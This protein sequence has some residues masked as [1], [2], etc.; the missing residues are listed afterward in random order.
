MTAT[1]IDGKAF[2]AQVRGQVAQHVTRLKDDHG[3]TPGL[4]VVLV[5][6]DPASEVYVK[7]K[8]KMTKEVGMKSVEHRLEDTT[9]EAEL[10][11]LIDALNNDDTIHGILVQ[12][13]LP[14]H[15]NE[16][17][18]ISAI[19]PAKDVDG[20][21]ISNVGFLGTG[22]KSMVPCTPLGCLM[23]LRDHHGSLSGM[24]AV[25]IGRSN[26]VG[27]PMAQLLLNDSC[28][29]TI[30]HSRTKDLAAVVRRADIVIAAVGRPEMVPGDWIKPGATVIDVGINRLD[31]PERGEGKTRLV[32]DVDFDSCVAVAGAITPVP[33]GVGPMTIACLL[34]NT[35]TAC[36]R[37]H[38]LPEPEGLTA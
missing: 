19:D 22:Q 21:H 11:S 26:I 28:T 14:D 3:I 32:G 25:V 6:A 38:D 18:V 20:F 17:L 35:V 9:S 27:K 13:P 23:M 33:G 15:L 12:L 36:C 37:A 24:D 10:L 1:I 8:G 29:V 16:D 2:A 4:A 30:A 7:S 5:G 31:A 34:A